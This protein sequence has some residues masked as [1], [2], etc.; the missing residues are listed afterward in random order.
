[1]FKR[2]VYTFIAISSFS[3]CKSEKELA[4]VKNVDLNRY[5]GKWFEIARLPNRFEKGL[6]CVTAN[7]T[8]INK[9]VEVLNIGHLV[10][11]P[12]EIK[13]AKGKAYVPDINY[14][15]RLR[16]TFF[17]PFYGDYYIISLDEKYQLALVGDPSR[18]YLWILSR[19]K[20]INAEAYNELLVKARN[21][22]FDVNNLVRVNQA[23]N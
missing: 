11:N 20:T 3:A 7:Y 16:V 8:V 18:K 6:E 1:M 5:A 4:T 2:L 22:G 23:C 14:P 12:T 21:N 10:G 9:K 17:W 13:K 19:S 15:G